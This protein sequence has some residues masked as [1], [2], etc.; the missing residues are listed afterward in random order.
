VKTR[1]L[2]IRDWIRTN[3]DAIDEHALRR[4]GKRLRNDVERREHILSGGLLYQ[5]AKAEG[6]RV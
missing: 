5:W 6:V 1:K 2:S 3:R 4:D